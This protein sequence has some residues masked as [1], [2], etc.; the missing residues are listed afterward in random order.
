MSDPLVTPLQDH[1]TSGADDEKAWVGRCRHGH[2]LAIAMCSLPPAT[3]QRYLDDM[4]DD[5]LTVSKEAGTRRTSWCV[6]CL[7]ER[8]GPA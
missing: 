3:G 8:T 2:V 6:A 5:G 4:L 1:L 7:G